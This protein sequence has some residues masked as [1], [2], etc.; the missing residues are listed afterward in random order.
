LNFVLPHQMQIV[1]SVLSFVIGYL[2]SDMI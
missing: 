1:G 2:C